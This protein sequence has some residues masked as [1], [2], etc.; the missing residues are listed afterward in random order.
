MSII[1]L[2]DKELRETMRALYLDI[3]K[4]PENKD[5]FDKFCQIYETHKTRSSFF[6]NLVLDSDSY[7]LYRKIAK[8]HVL[9]AKFLVANGICSESIRG[10]AILDFLLD[11]SKEEFLNEKMLTVIKIQLQS[12][13]RLSRELILLKDKILN[14]L[15]PELTESERARKLIEIIGDN[16]IHVLEVCPQEFLLD[17]VL[18]ETVLNKFKDNEIQ[19]S[20]ALLTKSI[21][22]S[23]ELHPNYDQ[24]YDAVIQIA[25]EQQ[26]LKTYANIALIA[27]NRP[28][29]FLFCNYKRLCVKEWLEILTH[30]NYQ[31]YS[32]SE[33]YKKQMRNVI[34]CFNL[35]WLKST[36]KELGELRKLIEEK[37]INYSD[38]L[39]A[40]EPT[41]F[42]VLNYNLKLLT[43]LETLHI[44]KYNITDI[45]MIDGNKICLNTINHKP[46]KLYIGK[47]DSFEDDLRGLAWKKYFFD[48]FEI[49]SK[50][51]E[52]TSFILSSMSV[53][54][55]LQFLTLNDL[56]KDL[57]NLILNLIES[58]QLGLN[59]Y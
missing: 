11:L 47:L 54:S 46:I 53:E 13:A 42:N 18:Y 39:T 48:N 33:E 35:F 30:Y 9:L 14:E 23:Y 24:K 20:E 19:I 44:A 7:D 43:P 27:K 10:N 8:V 28:D 4:D 3:L 17:P 5:N 55:L 45:T 38:I 57:Q 2:N 6:R 50:N 16:L 56:T 59:T 41:E 31:L 51:S 29:L 1:K 58:K 15:Y 36:P 49:F 21:I 34:S 37:F 52:L 25:V 22:N 12:P 40:K 32:T 26:L